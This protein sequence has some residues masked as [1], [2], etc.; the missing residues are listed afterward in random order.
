M[1]EN[2]LKSI[3][4]KIDD[5][6]TLPV[7][8]SKILQVVGATKT[9]SKD[10]A[11]VISKDP[12]LSAKILRMANSSFYGLRNEVSSIN[13]GVVILGFHT[14]KYLALG[15][16]SLNSIKKKNMTVSLSEEKFW[17][18]SIAC[19]ICARLIA[20]KTGYP[21]PEEAFVAGLIHDVGKLL[22]DKFLSTDYKKAILFSREKKRTLFEA[23]KKIV[24]VTHTT[25]GKWLS[26]EWG[27][28]SP[29]TYAITY[30]NDPPFLS[31][32]LSKKDLTFIS[33][34]YMANIICKQKGYK[35]WDDEIILT[36]DK[37]VTKFIN[38]KPDE[39]KTISERIKKELE[40][41]KVFFGIKQD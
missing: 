30:H 12:S 24:G 6:P 9:A 2:K 22:L 16:S 19:G 31:K 10:L 8:V 27:L 32:S 21:V 3:V 28:P 4:K 38:L 23:E 40:E 39:L 25:I 1:N 18:H 5:L 41:T 14:I 35:L 26:E 15:A 34:I 20:S 17:E 36:M 7:V 37:K 29:L 13:H 33:I 11:D